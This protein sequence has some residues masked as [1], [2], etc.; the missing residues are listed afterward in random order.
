VKL[1]SVTVQGAQMPLTAGSTRARFAGDSP[2][3]RQTTRLGSFLSPAIRNGVFEFRKIKADFVIPSGLE[4]D[5]VT[6]AP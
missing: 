4:S 2:G 5:W 1:E 6:V 3:L